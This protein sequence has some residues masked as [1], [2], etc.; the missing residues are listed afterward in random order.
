MEFNIAKAVPRDE[1]KICRI[2]L[3]QMRQFFAEILA[4][5]RVC[6]WVSKAPQACSIC[7]LPKTVHKMTRAVFY[8]K[9]HSV[10]CSSACNVCVVI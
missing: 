9:K 2:T 3:K 10:S 7:T 4:F 1:F 5:I 8:V 6:D